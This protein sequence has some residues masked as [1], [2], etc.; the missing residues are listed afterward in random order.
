MTD[1]SSPTRPG[2]LRRRWRYPATSRC[3]T[4]APIL[5]SMAEGRSRAT[6]LGPGADVVATAEAM[7]AV[8][9]AIDA[10]WIDSPGIDGWTAPGRPLDCANS[11]TTIRLLAGALS[12]RPFATTLSG[13]TALRRRPMRRLVA[14]LAALGAD[15]GV[16]EP[17]GTAPV[18]VRPADGLHGALRY[19]STSHPPSSARRSSWPLSRRSGR[20]W[21]A[22]PRATATTP[23]DGWRPWAAVR[24]PVPARSASTRTG[25]WSPSTASRETRRAPPSSGRRPAPTGGDGH[26]AECVPQPGADR[27]PPDPRVVRRRGRRRGDRFRPRRTGRGRS[28]SPGGAC[29]PST[30]PRCSPPSPWT[31]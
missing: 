20:R 24:S 8:G 23:N 9:V 3:P 28:P 22:V 10:G 31:S 16:K 17:Q 15:I 1:R 5:G 12:G 19:R 25:P 4:G 2:R 21:S 18:T 26:H 11:G 30:C 27:L 14:P 29:S 13:D 6:G 7:R